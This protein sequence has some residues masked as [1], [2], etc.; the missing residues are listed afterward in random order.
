M[1]FVASAWPQ[2][3]FSQKHFFIMQSDNNVMVHTSGRRNCSHAVAIISANN[4]AR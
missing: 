2:S 4:S 3:I 1:Y